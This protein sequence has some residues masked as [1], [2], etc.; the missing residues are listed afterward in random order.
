M[1]QTEKGR[2]GH[3]S[4]TV[5]T[6]TITTSSIP[7]QTTETWLETFT[8]R[9]IVDALNEASARYWDH[10]AD[11]LEDAAPKPG[12]FTGKATRAELSAAW[13]RCH[14]DAERCRR[15]AALLRDRSVSACRDD[16]ADL[17]TLES[18]ECDE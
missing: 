5:S 16:W 18:G 9:V 4:P 11:V 6:T 1:T 17:L 15:H 8:R 10:R 14:A 12:E 3:D 13:R 7:P 2:R